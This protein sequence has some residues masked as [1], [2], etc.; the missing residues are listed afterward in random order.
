MFQSSNSNKMFT[1]A[2]WLQ[3]VML[4]QMA[5]LPSVQ[6]MNSLGDN[7]DAQYAQPQ[8]PARPRADSD[9][10]TEDIGARTRSW[11]QR[12]RGSLRER[13]E[14]IGRAIGVVASNGGGTGVSAASA[15]SQIG[16]A[17]TG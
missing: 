16:R 14:S 17:F 8:A 10:A 4:A 2:L 1:Y 11:W 6:A 12:A 9:G 3:A 13:S 15:A 5:L 7:S